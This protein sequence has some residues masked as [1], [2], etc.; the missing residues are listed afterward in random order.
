MNIA[1]REHGIMMPDYF[2]GTSGV[3]LNIYVND[4]TT[5]S[6][7]LEELE[8]E[9]GMLWDHITFVAE[10][11]G[12][13]GE[14]AI[15]LIDERVAELRERVAEKGNGLSLYAKD[16]EFSDDEYEENPVAIFTI[17]FEED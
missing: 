14:D 12:W 7:V 5:V 13:K 4:D 8:S 1:I 16:V 15:I 6:D 17:E 11:N 9:I 10:Q 2:H 3:W